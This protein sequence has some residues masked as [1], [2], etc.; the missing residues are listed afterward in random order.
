[1]GLGRSCGHVSRGICE[2]G[3]HVTREEYISC[4]RRVEARKRTSYAGALARRRKALT[5]SQQTSTPQRLKVT[6]QFRHDNPTMVNGNSRR[7]VCQRRGQPFVRAGLV[8][9]DRLLGT[10]RHVPFQLAGLPER[11]EDQLWSGR[12]AG[13]QQLLLGARLLLLGHRAGDGH[14]DAAH[15]V[16]VVRGFG[17]LL[18]PHVDVGQDVLLQVDEGNRV[19]PVGNRA[20]DLDVFDALQPLE[21]P[22][23]ARTEP[24]RLMREDPVQLRPNMLKDSTA[25]TPVFEITPPK[26]GSPAQKI[27]QVPGIQLQY[28][29]N[30]DLNFAKIT[31]PHVS[32]ATL[33]P[34]IPQKFQMTT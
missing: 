20:H 30:V 19:L 23:P 22:G 28:S 32:V 29:R 21:G 18:L 13:Q 8:L 9:G 15:D 26:G 33:V 25:P 17:E 2:I 16:R 6:L 10:R 27:I 1:M 7:M 11:S 4:R 34:T 3:P 5:R 12:R 31:W 14:L 24:V